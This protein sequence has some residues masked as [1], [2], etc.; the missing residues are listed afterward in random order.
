MGGVGRTSNT[1]QLTS[2]NNASIVVVDEK[3]AYKAPLSLSDCSH[4]HLLLKAPQ[5]SPIPSKTTQSTSV[6]HAHT[7]LKLDL[8]DLNLLLKPPYQAHHLNQTH[9]PINPQ[10][11]PKTTT[12]HLSAHSSAS[13][14]RSAWLVSSR[15]LPPS[16]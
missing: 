10:L 6:R 3:A 5:S 8:Y 7:L 9:I 12:N 15:L 4:V 16:L 2:N 13:P 11:P 1:E 14:P